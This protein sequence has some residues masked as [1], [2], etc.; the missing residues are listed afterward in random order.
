VR[1]ADEP[2]E[3][4]E[5]TA[6]ARVLADRYGGD[7]ASTDWRH[8]GRLAGFTNRKPS[9]QLPTGY[10]P[11]ALLHANPNGMAPAAQDILAEG[12]ERLEWAARAK[13]QSQANRWQAG[14]SSIP[15]GDRRAGDAAQIAA[16]ARSKAAGNDQSASAKDFPAALSLLRRGF[17]EGETRAALLPC[18]WT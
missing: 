16:A 8:Y 15:L 18:R 6:A 4:D 10:Q 11:W 13:R 1:L 5:V 2:L 3:R 14:L 7:P 12:R 17:S 9:R